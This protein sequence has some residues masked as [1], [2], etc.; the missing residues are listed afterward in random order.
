[1]IAGPGSRLEFTTTASGSLTGRVIQGTTTT[2]FAANLTADP[3][4]PNEPT[5]VTTIQLGAP[6]Q[7]TSLRLV[8][9]GNSCAV[10]LTRPDV[11][12]LTGKAWRNP[13]SAA[14][15]ATAIAG[16]YN[17]GLF[18]PGIGSGY[19]S[20]N[21]SRT[22][23]ATV[24]GQ[25]ADGTAY[26]SASHLGAQGEVLVYQSLY[27]NQGG[28]HGVLSVNAVSPDMEDNTISASP[29]LE[30]KWWKP[31]IP[32]DT[33]FPEGLDLTFFV[34]GGIYLPPTAGQLVM[35]LDP[36][37]SVNAAVHFLELGPLPQGVR[38][39]ATGQVLTVLP[40]PNLISLSV[41]PSTGFFS[42]SITMPE[43]T[44]IP[45]R[46]IPFSGLIM[47][48]TLGQLGSGHFFVPV[49]PAEPLPFTR[50]PKFSGVV[51]LLA[52]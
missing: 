9:N 19:G 27:N 31:A 30:T 39:M 22:G 17:F 43:E 50:W 25:L 47:T 37:L 26:T 2:R 52:P 4:L 34:E 3:L 1:M 28:I 5:F 8:I 36:A 41:V 46:R 18:Y 48:T 21:A 20:I 6:E 11:G 14:N 49:P 45:L 38:V 29:L 7:E 12:Q 24:V 16:M 13:W 44:G 42:G 23:A 10:T 40:N 51:Q 33:V 32:E 35:D 15:P